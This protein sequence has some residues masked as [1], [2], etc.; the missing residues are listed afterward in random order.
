MWVILQV[1][2]KSMLYTANPELSLAFL[3]FRTGV[4]SFLLAL[5]KKPF[6]NSTRT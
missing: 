6:A 5:V 3:A 1:F 4:S 2:T